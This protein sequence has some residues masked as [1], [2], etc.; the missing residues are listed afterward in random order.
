MPRPHTTL[1]IAAGFIL[2]TAAAA[3]ADKPNLTGTWKMNPEKSDTN[4]GEIK[5]RV[6]KIEHQD[7]H[8]KITTTQ[9]DE[10][11]QNS[12]VRDYITDGRQ[13]T[14][15]ILGGERKSAAHWDGNSLV[16]ET[17]VTEGGYTIR[18]RW[19]VADD[20]RSIR[21]EREFSGSQGGTTRH[22]V[23]EKQ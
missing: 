9:D 7:P 17:K 8:L 3:A 20:K 19:T 10:N 13:M 14:H 2:L 23:L 18:D 1:C 12:V 21:I 5:S 6:D 15:S 16:I 22:I 4:S 11:G